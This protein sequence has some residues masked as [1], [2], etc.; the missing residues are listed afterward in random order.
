MRAAYLGGDSGGEQGLQ[1]AGP[2]V[3]HEGWEALVGA[4]GVRGRAGVFA[5]LQDGTPRL[6][7]RVVVPEHPQLDGEG[8]RVVQ[9]ARR[10]REVVRVAQ[11]ETRADAR[12]AW[13]GNAST[14]ARPGVVPVARAVEAP[15]H[16]EAPGS[17]CVWELDLLGEHLAVR[18][19][20]CAIGQSETAPRVVGQSGSG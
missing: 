10:D 8:L 12:A 4:D 20:D 17:D 9:L 3:E 14:A 1:L 16:V 13:L 19:A 11:L 5:L 15:L 6:R 2:G 18:I 7:G